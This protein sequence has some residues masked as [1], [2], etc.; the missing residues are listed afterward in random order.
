MLIVGLTGGIA[1]G[2]SV[3][4]RAWA[5]EPRICVVDAD[6]IVHTLYKPHT[7]VYRQLI[8]TFGK[9]ILD[10]KGE[11]DRR[12]LGRLIFNDSQAREKL[13]AIVHPAVRARLQDLAEEEEA[14]GAEVFVVEAALLLETDSVDRSFFDCY[15][16]T[17][18]DPDAQIKRLMARDGL[19]RDEALARI[20]SQTSQAEKI[21]QA[22]YLIATSGTPEETVERAKELLN[23][24][25]IEKVG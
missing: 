10:S 25:R 21:Q 6:Q 2:K 9:Q 15:I 14:K 1:S 7:E 11:I 20:R 5:Q 16:L 19:T 3:I 24:L 4:A 22:D 13:N 8:A 23:K 17:T 18:V 12:I